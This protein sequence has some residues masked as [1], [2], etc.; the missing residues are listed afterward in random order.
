MTFEEVPLRRL[1]ECLDGKRVPL[2]REERADIPGE[3]PY[4]G[5]GGVVD[6]IAHHLFDETLV[7]LGEDGAPFFDKTRPISFLIQGPS[8]VNNHIHVLRPR[9]IEPRFLSYALNAADYGRYIS[10]STRDKL[11]QEE[12]WTIRIPTPPAGP[13]ARIAD[14]LDDQVGRV[15]AAMRL[16]QEQAALLLERRR[17]VAD[18]LMNTLQSTAPAVRLKYLVR[19]RDERFADRGGDRTP[20]SVS[21][22]HGVIPRSEGSTGQNLGDNLDTYKVCDPG[23]IVLNRMRAFQGGVGVAETFGIVSPDYTVLTPSPQLTPAYLETVLRSPWFVGEMTRRIRGIGGT[24]QGNVRTPRINYSDLGDLR[25]PCPTVRVQRSMISGVRGDVEG[26]TSA[27]AA[28]GRREHLLGQRRG[29]LISAAVSGEL[30]VTTA[31]AV[32]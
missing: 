15:Q 6:H 1:V 26:I 3:I 2:N 21:I 11:T 32:A 14:F 28:L 20:L 4:W 24:D 23:D 27:T 18:E 16:T 12:M 9:A 31:R 29:S 5:S 19:E 8:W 13:Q 17:V 7:L 30:D 25:I 22:H 10:G